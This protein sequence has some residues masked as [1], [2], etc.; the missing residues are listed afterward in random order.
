MGNGLSPES[1][2][3]LLETFAEQAEQRLGGPA[4]KDGS[5]QK[6]QA[7]G[8][9]NLLIEIMDSGM[10]ANATLPFNMADL[11]FGYEDRLYNATRDHVAKMCRH[12][13]SSLFNGV[14]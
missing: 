4:A 8:Q 9:I 14:H 2:P 11:K 6:E 10:P 1:L 13:F 12:A 7:E 3:F 5:Q